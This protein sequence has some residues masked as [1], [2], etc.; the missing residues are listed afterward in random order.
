MFLAIAATEIEMVSLRQLIAGQESKW[1]TLVGGVGP[2]ETALRL[3]RFL[4]TQGQPVSGVINYGVAGAYLQPP[5][6]QQTD[7][8]DI[9]L[10]ERETLGDFGVCLPEGM[11]YLPEELTGRISFQLDHELRRRAGEILD[12][13]GIAARSGTF[14]T[15]SGVSG[16]RARGE[17][18]RQR[19]QGL[20]ENMEGAAVA[21]GC[22]DFALPLVEIRCISNMVE[23]RNPQGWR[24][25]EACEKAAAAAFLLLQ[26][27]ER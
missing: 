24:L 14:I 19:W 1:L 17:D 26:E 3:T 8:L 4:C 16:S 21:R 22:V 10:A 20:C 27:L 9:C 18:L 11:H 13:H 6:Q 12:K 2:V 5:G 15:V 23:D 25:A 7:L